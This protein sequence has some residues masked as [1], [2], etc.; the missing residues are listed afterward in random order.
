MNRRY[1]T[2]LFLLLGLTLSACVGGKAIE[3]SYFS[4]QYVLGETDRLTGIQKI[5]HKLQVNRFSASIAYDRQEIVYRSNPHEFR[6]YW[7]KLW[8]AKPEKLVREQVVTH[9]RHIGLFAEVGSKVTERR[10]HYELS[11]HVNAVE[12]LDSV[13]GRWFAHLDITFTVTR[14]EDG[15]RVFEQRYAKKKEVHER[16]PV[17]V[18]RALSEILREHNQAFAA[19]LQATLANDI[20]PSATPS[21]E[22][23]GPV[24]SATLQ[25]K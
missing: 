8:A 17:F 7:Y 9:L 6:Y 19:D 3:R 1:T 11:G 21:G 4:I 14:S 5:P 12:E 13:N 24:P 15:K 10:P 2:L 23:G 18:V 25:A 20:Q 22:D 16:R